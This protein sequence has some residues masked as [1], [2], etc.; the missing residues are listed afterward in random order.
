MGRARS[1]RFHLAA[2]A[3]LATVVLPA[4]SAASGARP[5][6]SATIS[7]GP[8]PATPAQLETALCAAAAKGPGVAG[9]LVTG[10]THTQYSADASGDRAA[11]TGAEVTIA[12]GGNCLENQN[13]MGWGAENPEPSPGVDDFASLD[14]RMRLIRSTGGTPVLTLCCAPDWMK[15]GTAGATDWSR[16]DVAPTPEHFQDFAALA[17]AVAQRYPD[18]LHYQV[19]SELKGFWNPRLNRWDYEGYT[20]LYNMVYDALKSVNPTIQVGGPYMVLDSEADAAQ[21]SNPSAVRGVWG[22]LDQRTVDA[23]AYWLDHRRGAD[24]LAVD[25]GTSSKDGTLLTDEFTAT[26]KFSDLTTWLRIRTS[27]P[28]WWSE[29]YVVPK[30]GQTWSD[31]HKA[32]VVADALARMATAGSAAALLWQPQADAGGCPFAC[33]WTDTHTAGGGKPTA[34]AAL[35]PVLATWLAGSG[36]HT[37]AASPV[38]VTAFAT[39]TSLLVIN[40]TGAPV[41][42]SVLGTEVLLPAYGVVVHHATGADS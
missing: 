22:T 36:P 29:W 3:C 1:W 26:A 34:L 35:W 9:S 20:A 10:I 38:T 16:L 15:G 24:F 12:A 8:N 17:K 23:L 31:E 13:L 37:V 21:M 27:L 32:A 5:Q 4:C 2:L 39:G 18:V 40:T 41:T 6:A 25:A 42:A 11:I 30:A 33:L 7:P 14:A 19:W 28:V